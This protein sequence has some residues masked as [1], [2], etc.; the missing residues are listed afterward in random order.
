MAFLLA[1]PNCGERSVY[2]FRFG[3]EVTPRPEPDASR[4]KWTAYFYTRRNVA[5]DQREWWYH[6][7]GCRK[8]VRGRAR[9]GDQRGAP[10]LLAEGGPLMMINS[11]QQG[12]LGAHESQLID[13][14]RMVAFDFD[15]WPVKANEGDTIASALYGAGI[16]TLSRS[17]K[18]H[19]AR[20]LLCVA[21]RCANCMVTVDG[22]PNV[23]ACIVPARSG[24]QVRHQNAWPSLDYDFM[25]ILDRLDRF[26]P[27]G[28]YY[29]AL[30]RPRLLWRL[31]SPII[32]RI[33]G[34]GAVDIESVSDSPLPP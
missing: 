26:L 3:G 24:M 34:L 20:G 18:Y 19:R 6:S 9:Y 16:R 5:G 31:A 4:E 22:V 13:R 12:R 2:E 23:R 29:K 27:V 17:F 1:C 33:A 28:F 8:W 32:R 7:F 11:P 25:S 15:G 30:H 21:G 14:T 10:D